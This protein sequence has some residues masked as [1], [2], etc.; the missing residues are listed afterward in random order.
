[1]LGEAVG[2]VA[3]IADKGIAVALPIFAGR[4]HTG[5]DVYAGAVQRYGIGQSF[6]DIG[7]RGLFAARNRR[8][9]PF[10]GIGITGGG[11]KQHLLQAV[12]A[13]LFR[14]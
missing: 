10:S 13:Q 7:T 1:M 9:P 8:Q 12:A 5:H 3:D 2:G 4:N 14:Q 11:I 6:V